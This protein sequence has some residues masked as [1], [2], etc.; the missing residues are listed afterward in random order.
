MP[1]MV[2]ETIYCVLQKL[3]R[4]LLFIYFTIIR[5]RILGTFVSSALESIAYSSQMDIKVGIIRCQRTHM[6]VII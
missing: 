1:R 2:C 5:K 4:A 6:G 3:Q